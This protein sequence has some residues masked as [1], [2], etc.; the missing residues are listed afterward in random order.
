[1][2]TLG[3]AC[4]ETP[5]HG[6]QVVFTDVDGTCV[7]YAGDGGSN[8][9]AV[10]ARE[11]RASTSG[12]RTGDSLAVRGGVRIGQIQAVV[13]QGPRGEARPTEL[14]ALPES[15]S[16][17]RGLI[18]CTTLDS[19]DRIR[20]EKGK[21]LVVISGC[22]YS[23]LLER[24]PFIPMADVYACESGGRIF[25]KSASGVL[26][27][28][29]EWNEGMKD[30]LE[31]LMR[32]KEEVRELARSFGEGAVKVD[33]RSYTTAFRV[34]RVDK[35]AKD[36]TMDDVQRLIRTTYPGLDSTFNLGCLDVYPKRSGKKNAAVH[37]ARQAGG[38]DLASHA[39]FLCDDDNDI[40]L[41]NE[42]KRVYL[43]NMSPAVEQLVKEDAERAG[44]A[45]E[46]G[47]F[48]VGDPTID[49]FA[50]TEKLLENLLHTI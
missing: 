36:T 46:E 4:H 6:V 12:T 34:R 2:H 19:Y 18:S 25:Y 16:G 41:A 50:R 21:L 15:S 13:S 33:D 10:E 38:W 1:M 49:A 24:L 29:V 48:V 17:S 39:V 7:H 28:D 9:L 45:G 37:I 22:R 35:C 3:S 31:E 20:H 5:V 8:G 47:K 14:V 26:Y 44:Q 27:E 23:T 40:E 43:P 32:C 11:R 42:V 30:Q